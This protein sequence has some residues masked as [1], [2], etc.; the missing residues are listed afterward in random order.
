MISM[1]HP[2]LRGTG[3]KKFKVYYVTYQTKVVTDETEET[4]IEPG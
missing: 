1:T 2:E 3:A 4:D